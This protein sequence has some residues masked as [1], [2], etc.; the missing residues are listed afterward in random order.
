MAIKIDDL[1]NSVRKNAGSAKNMA[2]LKIR[3]A[4]EKN[5]LGE[6][7]RLLGCICYKNI[8][9]GT[10]EDTGV[11]C[12][13]I[14]NKIDYIEEIKQEIN[15]IEGN[16]ECPSCRKVASNK[17]AFCP[18]CG[19]K[20][21]AD[22]YSEEKNN[23]YADGEEPVYESAGFENITE[24]EDQEQTDESAAENEDQTEDISKLDFSDDLQDS[25]ENNLNSDIS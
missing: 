23:S 21:P 9:D 4:R 10:N 19:E 2:E 22:D 5:E 7:Y 25:D 1:W 17:Y 18:F 8:A 20:L 13:D 3:L 11:L 14:K 16:I 6:L 15:R 12:C 24:A